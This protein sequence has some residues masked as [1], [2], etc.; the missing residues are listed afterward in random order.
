[1]RNIGKILSV[2]LAV[3]LLITVFG[4]AVL[5]DGGNTTL[6]AEVP[7]TVSMQIGDHGKV[8]VGGTDYT[9]EA[10]VTA[11]KDTVLTYVFKPALLYKLDKVIYNGADVTGEVSGDSYTAPALTGN[12][13]LSVSFKLIQET[14]TYTVTFDANGH[15]TAPEKQSVL[16]DFKATEPEKLTAE[17]YAFG[18]W[19][20]EK[21]CVNAFDFS[22]PIK[23]SI[24]LYAKWTANTCVVTFEADGGTP[25]PSP[26]TVAYNEKAARPADPVKKGYDFDGWYSDKTSGIVFDFSTP[27]TDNVTLYAKWTKA[28]SPS[29]P[30]TPPTPSFPCIPYY[31]FF[32]D[33]PKPI[34]PVTP[35]APIEPAKPTLPFTDVMPDSPYFEDIQYVYE[36]DLMNGM[37]ETEFGEYL[38]LTRG[39]IVTV[40]H[41][42]EGKPEVTYSGVFTDVPDGQ[43]YTDGVEWAASH[44]IVLG[45]GD[46]RYGLDDNVTR[47]Q[48]AAILHRYAKYNG[49]DV[50]VG[51]D[52]NILSYNDAFTWGDWAVPALQW[53]C[54]TGVL[55]DIPAGMLRPTEPATIGEIAHAIH[56]F[57]EDVLK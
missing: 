37:S 33:I 41:R 7:C 16:E 13:S 35:V 40:L 1:M 24:T 10:S 56:V 50:S 27:I 38:P 46:G 48:L 51:D 32:P 19:Y 4:S 31:P 44:G 53:A 14:K 26:Q 12:A 22:T 17:G 55:E 20:T 18:G 45:Y 3:V 43:W 15:G 6:T 30:V 23:E 54:G 21:N 8:S 34:A 52:T 49:C 25:A 36:N 42:M 11:A 39:M 47:E 5:A 57:C 9:G 28:D 2:F 29:T